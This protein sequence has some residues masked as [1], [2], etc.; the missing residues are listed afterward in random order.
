MLNIEALVQNPDI[1]DSC[2]HVI[3]SN[4]AHNICLNSYNIFSLNLEQ[5][6]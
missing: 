2:K 3:I 1:V 4:D 5:Q 6:N